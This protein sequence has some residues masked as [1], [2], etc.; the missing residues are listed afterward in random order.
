MTLVDLLGSLGGVL[1]VAVG[2]IWLERRTGS[3]SVYRAL[4]WWAKMVVAALAFGLPWIPYWRGAYPALPPDPLPWA[5]ALS[6]VLWIGT[7]L[8]LA[9]FVETRPSTEAAC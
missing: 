2:G 7:P 6:A 3:P 9:R 4:P 1:L 8:L 5:F